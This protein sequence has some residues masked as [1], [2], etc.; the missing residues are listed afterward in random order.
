M[1]RMKFTFTISILSISLLVFLT[2]SCNTAKELPVGSS[3]ARLQETDVIFLGHRGG[4]ASNYSSLYIENTMPSIL[5]GL[6]T[7]DGVEADIQMSLDGTI[8]LFHDPD[9]S[10]DN[11]NSSFNRSLI[12][13]RDSAISTLQRCNNTKHDRIYR[14]SE[15]FAHWNASSAGYYVSLEVKTDFPVDTFA[16][17]GGRQAYLMRIADTLGP[18]LADIKHPDM[19]YMEAQD[20]SFCTRLRNYRNGKLVKICNL[21]YSDFDIQISN[22][23][24]QGFNGISCLFSDTSITAEKIKKAQDSGLVVQLWTPYSL[25]ELKDAFVKHPN[26]IQSDNLSAKSLL[27]VK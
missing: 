14:L 17:V 10:R 23:L 2:L 16:V 6:K 27:K 22:S 13:L 25:D 8:W 3:P 11:C 4:G 12:L 15:L 7:M 24:S 26:I 21:I 1:R 20:Q 19:L 5:D 18:M 9:L